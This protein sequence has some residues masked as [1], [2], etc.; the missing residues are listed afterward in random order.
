MT[1]RASNVLLAITLCGMLGACYGDTVNEPTPTPDAGPDAVGGSGGGGSNGS[2]GSS[3]GSSGGESSHAGGSGGV[4]NAG[5]AGADDDNDDVITE[6]PVPPECTDLDTEDNECF[7]H[8][9][10]C[11]A[12]GRGQLYFLNGCT[13]AVCVPFDNTGLAHPDPATIP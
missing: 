7:L 11:Q 2:S 9:K 6:P 8:S 1:Y 3:G 12:T 13:D 10:R 4:G 5:H